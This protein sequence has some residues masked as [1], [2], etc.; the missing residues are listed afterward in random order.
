MNIR[1][2]RV[3]VRRWRNFRDV[4]LDIPPDSS[5]VCLVGENGTGK[6]NILELVSIAAH[7]IGLTPGLELNRDQP[8]EHEHDMEVTF[9][10][11][12]PETSLVGWEQMASLA[13]SANW[14][15][16]LT[17]RMFRDQP[18]WFPPKVIAGGAGDRQLR[19]SLGQALAEGIRGNEELHHLFL[20]A[21]RA[22]PK[23]V[24]QPHELAQA[25][26]ENSLALEFLK[27]AAFKPS[28]NLYDD[29]IRYV[30]ATE[31]QQSTKFFMGVREAGGD[32]SQQLAFS[33][34][35]L[36]ESYGRDISA[37][38]PHIEFHGV[39]IQ[40]RR[41]LFKSAGSVLD[42]GDLSGGEREI[43]FL[44][45][46]IHRFGLR[47][48]LFLVDEPELHLN[49]S[50]IRSWVQYLARTI[51]EGQ[52][53]LATHSLE[54][55]ETIGPEATWVLRR[56]SE[57]RLV[58]AA[59][60]LNDRPALRSLGPL[61][62]N[63]AFAIDK[64]PFV[65]IEGD[66]GGIEH[67][68]FEELCKGGPQVKFLK[69]GSCTSVINHFDTISQFAE[70]SNEPVR[71]GAVIDR[72]F[73]GKQDRAT[74]MAGRAIHILGAHEVENFFIHPD[75]LE[76][77]FKLSN[78][79]DEPLDAI[80]KAVEPDAGA[81]ILQ[82][83]IGTE[84]KQ[85]PKAVSKTARDWKWADIESDLDSFTSSLLANFL[86]PPEDFAAR[87]EEHFKAWQKLLVSDELWRE[88]MGKQA[89]SRLCQGI[90]IKAKLFEAQALNYWESGAVNRPPELEAL[91]KYV[92][93]L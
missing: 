72:D 63:P 57:S 18:G 58:T 2:T 65:L 91:R 39:D 30:L 15:N 48:G 50:M 55:V 14:D 80:R 43:I 19:E 60:T 88:C 66:V 23:P 92:A 13:T 51:D 77:V 38:L 37:V 89:L 90:G 87:I 86:Q 69:V 54:A 93:S 40:K 52:V 85:I 35:D 68:R 6:S 20:D 82:H 22:Y 75:L 32:L 26:A 81:W 67:Q 83:A 70:Q 47:R 17:V 28:K 12:E 9:L 73:R 61:L 71:L 79:A 5:V 25:F 84:P 31:S 1:V 10:L 3:E 7:Q 78:L 8:L 4:V 42:F 76:L 29:W 33:E 74:L 34:H 27:Q 62:G 44:L 56:D 16:T 64:V 49:V 41:V 24:L 46:N 45:G 36:F 21:D 11:G 53:W 59:R